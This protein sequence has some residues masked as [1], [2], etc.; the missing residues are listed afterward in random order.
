MGWLVWTAIIFTGLIVLAR[1]QASFRVWTVAIGGVLILV[2][3]TGFLALFPGLILW[4]A[5]LLIITPLNITPLRRKY[6]SDPVLAYIRRILPPMSETEK[7]A[8]GAGTVWWEAELFCGNPNWDKLLSIPASR[9][10][11]EEQAFLDGPVEELC[12]M[13]NDWQITHELNDLP[14][15]VWDFIKTKGFFGLIIPKEYG[16]HGFTALAHSTVVMKVAS[17][18]STA[19]VTV[20]VPNSLGPAELL[21][22]YGTQKQKDYYLP[23]LAKGEE[24]PCFALTSPRAG[25]DASGIPDFGIVCKGQFEGRET[26]GL[27]CTWEKRYITLGPIATLLG[28]AFKAYDPDHLL[29][30]TEALGITCALIPIGTPGVTIGKRHY[31]LDIAFQN[32]P[33]SGKDVFVPMDWVIGGRRGLGRGWQMLM[34]SLSAGRGISLPALSAGGGKFASRMTGAYARVRKQF[35]RPIGEFEG[36]EE[37]LARIGG[38]TYM[39]DAARNLTAAA[40]DLGEKPSVVS[41]IVKYHNTEAL[42]QV[43]ND[44]MDIHAG[45][46]ICLGPSNY[47]GRSYGSLPVAITV[48]GAN[49]LTRSMI[50]FGQGA[51]RCHPYLVDELRAASNAD[52]LAARVVFDRI[53]FS[54]LGY[55]ASNAA[56]AFVYGLSA[57]RLAPKPV[58]GPTAKYYQRLASMSASFAFLADSALLFLG[59]Q[60]K[61]KEKL[62]GRFADAL[63][64]LFLCSAALKRYED[65][66]RPNADLP[67]VEWVA[68]Y[69]LYNVQNAMDEIMRNFPS[70]IGGQILRAII[71]P[72]GHKLRYPNDALGHKVASLLLEPSAVRDRLTAGIYIND[73]PNDVSGRVEYALKKVIEAE[74]IERKLVKAGFKVPVF[75]E[76][77][78]WLDKAVGRGVINQEEATLVHEALRATREAIMVDDFAPKTQQAKQAQEKAA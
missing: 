78:S 61:R 76:I 75:G 17:R 37:A 60:L 41:A 67:V 73:D 55:T 38:L 36:V 5:F 13:L 69:C 15:E 40:L 68:K 22:H 18:S 45:R 46:G 57:A 16:G 62:S 4:G 33:N 20:M 28:L 63:S 48:E 11:A 50:I 64:Y 54:H 56:R 77:D 23:R 34:E 25:S 71:F 49:I 12:G 19:A 21:M 14:L 29:G 32:G 65:Q 8:I 59:G 26:L 39:M 51:M 52:A 58:S 27:R 70:F 66:D 2:S 53:L 24:I 43:T 7:V 31:P 6:F 47:L 1:G 9:L 44:S 42:R 72:L 3:F 35:N 10:T 74:P 30:D